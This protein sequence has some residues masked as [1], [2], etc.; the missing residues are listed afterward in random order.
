MWNR[1]I[2]SEEEPE[3]KPVLPFEPELFCE[4]ISSFSGVTLIFR[5]AGS[6]FRPYFDDE[7]A[8]IWQTA[9]FDLQV[10]VEDERSSFIAYSAY[11]DLHT[12]TAYYLHYSL[13]YEYIGRVCFRILARDV[14]ANIRARSQ[15]VFV[16]F[17][18]SPPTVMS[19]RGPLVR[20]DAPG[21][22]IIDLDSRILVP[23]EKLL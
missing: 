21:I 6:S 2:K 23:Q 9:R 8:I 16:D 13:P 15:P 3:Q 14:L 18:Q 11:E 20:R 17:R 19:C 1:L 4:Q 10:S 5:F 12:D 22:T 7:H